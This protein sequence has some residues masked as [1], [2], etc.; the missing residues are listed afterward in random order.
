[1]GDDDY[2]EIA[3]YLIRRYGEAAAE[4]ADGRAEAHRALGEL[5]GDDLWRGIAAAVRSIL[6]GCRP[7]KT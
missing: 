3:R 5:G 1:M 6:F 2:H 4:F 7:K